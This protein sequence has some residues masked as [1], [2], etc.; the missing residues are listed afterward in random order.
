MKCSDHR[1]ILCFPGAENLFLKHL[2]VNSTAN[3]GGR[4]EMTLEFYKDDFTD[5]V[6]KWMSLQAKR[7]IDKSTSEYTGGLTNNFFSR[8]VL[9]RKLTVDRTAVLA[10]YYFYNVIPVE[11]VYYEDFSGIKTARFIFDYS[12]VEFY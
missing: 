12:E 6:I 3:G 7:F 10:S 9:M 1:T 4:G 8:K 11:I 2:Y 5:W